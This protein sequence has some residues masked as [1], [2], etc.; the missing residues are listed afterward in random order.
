MATSGINIQGVQRV[1]DHLAHLPR[2]DLEAKRL[3]GDWLQAQGLGLDPDQLDVVTLHLRSHEPGR[4]QAQ[5]M[6]RVSLTEAVLTNWQGESDNDVFGALIAAPWAGRLPTDGVIEVVAALG[7]RP[8]FENGAPYQVYNGVFKRGEAARF[9]ASTLVAVNAQAL[10]QHIETLDFHTRYHALLDDYWRVHADE[11]RLCCKLNLVAACNKQVSE[12]SL[13]EGARQLIWQAAE[14]LPRRPGLRLQAL[15]IYGYSATDLLCL[16]D[17][18]SDLIVLYAPGN[19]SPLLEF[20]S[21]DL[22][23]DWIGQQCK[24]ALGR[25]ELKRHFRLADGPQG[26]DF[27]GLDTALEGLAAY[28]ASHRLPPEHGYFND[29]GTWPPRTYVNYRPDHYSPAIEGDLFQALT[30]RQRQRSYDD[31]DFLIT[32]NSEIS[33]RRW[34]GYLDSTL[35]LLLPLSFVVP[36]LA[37]LLAVGGIVQL[38]LGLDQAINGKTL[39]DRLDGVDHVVYGVFNAVP[40]VAQAA[41]KVADSLFQTWQDGFVVPTRL[42][43]QIGYPLSPIDP[44]RLPETDIAAYFHRPLRIEPLP[45]GDAEV[46]DAVHRYPR[47]NGG[48][49]LLRGYYEPFEGYVQELELVYDLES[50]L[51]LTEEGLN[52]IQPSWYEPDPGTGN[53]RRVAPGARPTTDAM[54]TAT[55]RGLGIDLPLPVELP[56]FEVEGAEPIP[57]QITSLWVGNRHIEDS[58]LNNLGYNAQL[59]KDSPYRYRLLLS[60]NDPDAFAHNL[61]QLTARAPGLEVLPLEEQAFFEAFKQHPNYAQYLTATSGPASNLASAADVLRYPMLHSE[62]GLY[63]DIDDAL[64]PLAGSDAAAPAMAALDTVELATTPDGLL[65]QPPLQNELMGL[66]SMYNNSMIG[67]HAGNPTLLRICEEMQARYLST[68]EPYPACPGRAEDPSG[69][70][71][72]ARHVSWLTGPALLTDTVDRLLPDLQRLRQLSHLFMMPCTNSAAFI[73]LDTLNALREVR[74]PLKRVARIGNLHSWARP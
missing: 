27:S 45:G 66:N 29:D 9:D 38:G 35:N 21:H 7:P 32:S 73:D 71:R 41:S 10:Q 11:H 22:L 43:D 50:G 26:V 24:G 72:F 59:L 58:V 13:S 63:M 56:S 52:E 51:F 62:G 17:T 23:K 70:R 6:Q 55:L 74:L 15:N 19:S 16:H 33:K 48:H 61:A 64:L 65:L 2:P 53:V 18:H 40:F 60:S 25:R 37:P 4:Y 8:W 3:I 49:D 42:H 12:G 47:Y 39:Q 46:A 57:K 28:P 34:R 44:P 31:A 54:R 14:L 68:P 67:S 1:R 20:A 36:G 69:F 30:D 5:V